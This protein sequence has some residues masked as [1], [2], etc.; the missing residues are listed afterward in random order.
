MSTRD[1]EQIKFLTQRIREEQDPAT[2][3]VLMMELSELVD[4]DPES[5]NQPKRDGH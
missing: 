5:K 3:L 2:L 1:Q 4:A